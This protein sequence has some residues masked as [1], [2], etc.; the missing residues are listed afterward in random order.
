[1]LFGLVNAPSTFQRVMNETLGDLK[2][3]GVFTYIDDIIIS[4]YNIQE[5]LKLL[6]VFKKL[7]SADYILMLRNVN[8]EYRK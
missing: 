7:V 1:M 3:E 4:S 2:N 8:L 6:V 5:H